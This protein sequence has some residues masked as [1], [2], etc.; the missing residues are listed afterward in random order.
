M[1]TFARFGHCASCGVAVPNGSARCSRCELGDIRLLT[2][3]AQLERRDARIW[4]A[5]QSAAVGCYLLALV[6][7]AV[8][9][10]PSID[11]GGGL[12]GVLFSLGIC[13]SVAA[14][15]WMISPKDRRP[16]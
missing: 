4:E 7:A 14:L 15:G 2:A 1:S 6:L 10:G 3:L 12:R 5:R 9:V 16:R 13:A 8:L 11:H